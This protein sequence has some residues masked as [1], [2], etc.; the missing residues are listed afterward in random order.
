MDID[1]KKVSFVL[2]G[3]VLVI[4]VAQSIVLMSQSIVLN[5]R[6]LECYKVV[7]EGV[8]DWKERDEGQ[9]HKQ[10]YKYCR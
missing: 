9:K 5:N 3:F 4:L 2:G 6:K 10:W 8:E 7:D 1:I